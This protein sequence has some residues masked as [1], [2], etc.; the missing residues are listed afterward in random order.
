MVLPT[1]LQDFRQTPIVIVLVLARASPCED[2][3]ARCQGSSMINDNQHKNHACKFTEYYQKYW[4][5]FYCI[6]FVILIIS[7]H[8]IAFDKVYMFCVRSCVASAIDCRHMTPFFCN[9][10]PW[11]FT[12]L[13]SQFS[14]I[15]CI[16]T[17][18]RLSRH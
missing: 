3:Y 17:K 7:Y 14:I 8:L 6:F 9:F 2:I 18:R 13:N 5:S 1:L 11:L 12:I 15:R 16:R 10:A 4:I